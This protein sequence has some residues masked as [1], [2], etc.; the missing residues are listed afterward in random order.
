MAGTKPRSVNLC[1]TEAGRKGPQTLSKDVPQRSLLPG[2][3]CHDVRKQP[4]VAPGKVQVEYLELLIPGKDCPP[5]AQLPRA[6]VQSPALEGFESHVDV[7]PG[8]VGQWCLGCA[9]KWFDSMILD[10]FSSLNDSVIYSCV[11]T[12]ESPPSTYSVHPP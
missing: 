3:R 1:K 5:L 4:Q 6:V 8:D 11:S 7:A 9:G 10:N 12:A 2:R